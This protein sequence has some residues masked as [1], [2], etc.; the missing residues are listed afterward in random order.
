MKYQLY[1][2]NTYAAYFN[3]E[4]SRI[5]GF[6]SVV[7]ELLPMQIKNASPDSF[8]MWLRE[9]AIDLNVLQHRNLVQEMY[10]TRD[11]ISLALKTHMF[12]LTDTFTCFPEGE[13]IERS[14]LF[15]Q[16]GQNRVSEYILLSSDTS[17]NNVGIASP[18]ISTDGSFTKTWVY[19]NGEWW[20]YKLQSTEATRS[21]VNISRVLKK[22]IWDTADYAYV[23]SYRKRV[24]SRNFLG[25][26]EF[27][28]P[29]ESLRYMFDDTGDD[30]DII[31]RNI[32]SLGEEFRSAW[33]K[34]L[35]ADAVFLNTDRHMRNFGVIRS[36]QTGKIL[37]LAPNFDNNQ[38]Y[39]AN[40]S[41]KYSDA[42]L[43]GYMRGADKEDFD[44][45]HVLAECLRG[46]SYL[47]EAST[48]AMVYLRET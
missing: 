48:A 47:E 30:D 15:A 31:F 3:V 11:K 36:S 38:A 17:L 33:K 21:E 9:R 39:K 23:G 18:N 5:T 19:E 7:P 28:E 13:Y 40:P 43:R 44:N 45:L 26:N 4:H 27:F 46:A 42:M 10:G 16:E 29:Y 32:A 1:N 6:E 12:S 20:L 2:G 34:I 25:E 37:R 22:C 24:K 35:I 41:G 8:T 14:S